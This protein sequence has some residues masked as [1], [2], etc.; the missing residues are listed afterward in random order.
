MGGKGRRKE[1]TCD[2]FVSF[3]TSPYLSTSIIEIRQC[4]QSSSFGIKA[5]DILH[6]IR[7]T[8]PI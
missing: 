6:Y 1:G 2:Y 5:D 3:N 4:L 8:P 7:I